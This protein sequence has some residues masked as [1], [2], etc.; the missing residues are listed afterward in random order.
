MMTTENDMALHKFL[1]QFKGMDDALEPVA[2]SVGSRFEKIFNS[3]AERKLW[4]P[5]PASACKA[6]NLK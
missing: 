1:S 2:R 6:H 3:E 4:P 5:L